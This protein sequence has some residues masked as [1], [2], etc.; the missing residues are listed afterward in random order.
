MTRL[1]SA[2]CKTWATT[3]PP[4]RRP[5]KRAVATRSSRDSLSTRPIGD[6]IH[7]RAWF[8]PERSDSAS[9]EIFSIAVGLYQWGFGHRPGE[10]GEKSPKPHGPVG[11]GPKPAPGGQNSPDPGCVG[12]FGEFRRPGLEL[13]C[14]TKRRR[15]LN[16]KSGINDP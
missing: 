13:D 16:P 12:D 7:P 4:L 14:R 6:L 2:M 3:W 10:A 9:A 5:K 8:S 15:P 1:T 11:S